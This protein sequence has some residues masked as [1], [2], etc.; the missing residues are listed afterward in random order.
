[1]MLRF[2]PGIGWF[3]IITIL[4]VLPGNEFPEETWFEKI[5]LDKWI[6]SLFFFVLL[7]L[8]YT[9]LRDQES[10]WLKRITICGIFYGVL[11]EIIQQ[12]FAS[13]RSFD[14]I[15]IVFDAIGCI[16]AYF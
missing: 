1:M 12:Y 8:F 14:L 6:H 4:F 7:Y 13:G 15:D 16:A 10:K 2:L 3:I 5:Y 9:P 11:I